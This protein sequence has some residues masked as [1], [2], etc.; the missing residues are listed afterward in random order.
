MPEVQN[1]P[2][3][4]KLLGLLLSRPLLTLRLAKPRRIRNA[5]RSFLSH[6]GNRGQL[7]DRYVEIYGMYDSSIQIQEPVGGSRERGYKGTVLIF[8]IIDWE[9]RYARP[10]HFSTSPLLDA[11]KD[12]YRIT[13]HPCENVYVCRLRGA[14]A[15]IEDILRDKMGPHTVDA[16]AKSLSHFLKDLGIESPVVV[17]HHPYWLPLVRRIQGGRIGYDCM[18]FH[19]GFLGETE[20]DESERILLRTADFVVAS[21]S[22]LQQKIGAM[23]RDVPLIRNGCEYGAF[24]TIGPQP[25]ADIPVAGYVGA[26]E[27]WFDMDLVVGV[28]TRLPGW[29]FVIIGSSLGCNIDSARRMR[30]IEFVGEVPYERVP[31]Q[32]ARFDVCMIPFKITELIK[33][34]NPVKV[35]EYLAAG[36]PVVATPIPELMV[37]GDKVAIASTTDEF[38]ANLQKGLY[39]CSEITDKWRHWAATQDWSVRAREFENVMKD[40]IGR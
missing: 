33:A 35:Y 2:G 27:E 7:Y 32:L 18:D 8:P 5:I 4:L 28:A 37:L 29:R 40:E 38:A 9:Y 10:Q 36:R 6:R 24:S 31:A 22:Y 14:G 1:L 39:V 11:G 12:P 23:R 25:K 13:R 20:M 34:T 16:Y 17:L 21:S 3:I 30:N 19:R 15:D 26:V